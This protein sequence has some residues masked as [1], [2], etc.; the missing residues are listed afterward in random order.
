MCRLGAR[1]SNLAFKC[2]E[3]FS[4]ISAALDPTVMFSLVNEISM[5][6][7]NITVVT[8][9]VSDGSTTSLELAFSSFAPRQQSKWAYA[10]RAIT[11]NEAIA[12]LG[13]TQIF[14]MDGK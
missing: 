12:D 3:T 2:N 13:A 1:V 4:V 10:T 14:I 7:D 9:N 5:D 6:D 11:L 8:S